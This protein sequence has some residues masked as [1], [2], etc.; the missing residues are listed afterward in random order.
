VYSGDDGITLPILSV[1]GHG[2]VSVAGHVIGSEIKEMISAFPTD[3]QRAKQIHH[4][5]MPLVKALFAS[6]SPVPV[7]YCLSLLGFDTKRVRLPLVELT[8]AEAAPLKALVG[9]MGKVPAAV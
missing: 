6:P 8:D 5:V 1:G 9:Q 3:P 4:K 2:V 7:K